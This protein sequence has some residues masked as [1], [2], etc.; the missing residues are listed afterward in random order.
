MLRIYPPFRSG[1]ANFITMPHL[2]PGQI[3]SLSGKKPRKRIQ[4]RHAVAIPTL[5]HSTQTEPG[6]LV[7]LSVNWGKRPQI[8]PMDSLRVDVFG[9]CENL[10]TVIEQLLQLLRWRSRQWWITRSVAPLEGFLR[11]ELPV[12]RDGTLVGL[13]GSERGKMR[14]VTGNELPIDK[15]L[16]TGVIEDFRR[17]LEPPIYDILLLD[18]RY[19]ASTGESR[20][21]VLD[22]ASAIEQARDITIEDLWPLHG[23]QR[24]FHRD[25]VLKGDKLY[26]HLDRDLNNYIGRSY[27]SEHPS[28]FEKI[29]TL[30]IARHN[31]AHGG[32]GKY[33]RGGRTVQIDDKG[34]LEFAQA[35]EDCVR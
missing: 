6:L 21:S 19:F 29:K 14:T 17:G 30:W 2:D 13:Q 33:R 35:A 10:E 15:H 3:P 16:W 31:I 11:G 28:Q 27:K 9:T 1:P 20:Q 23:D 7:T 8:F 18:A 5:V 24:K 4:L 12:L 25:K 22:S 32:S 26:N 34:A